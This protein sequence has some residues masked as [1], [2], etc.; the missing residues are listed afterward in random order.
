VLLLQPSAVYS[1]RPRVIAKTFNLVMLARFE[2]PCS[3]V[4]LH[5][6]N[7]LDGV[8]HISPS[9]SPAHSLHTQRYSTNTGVEINGEL[10]GEIFNAGLCKRA[11]V[12]AMKRSVKLVCSYESQTHSETND[13][14]S[15]IK[16]I[17]PVMVRVVLFSLV[18]RVHRQL[19]KRG[20]K[21]ET[22]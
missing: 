22:R 20:Q 6:D 15:K 10:D 19:K 7:L 4:E 9:I 5:D 12:V 21:N 11:F 8:S 13:S 14:P 2:P 18:T 16:T 1:S 3:T 17:H